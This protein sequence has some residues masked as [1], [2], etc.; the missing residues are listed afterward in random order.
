MLFLEDVQALLFLPRIL[1]TIPWFV[2]QKHS[3]RVEI[4]KFSWLY[5]ISVASFI[6][7]ISIWYG[8]DMVR[9]ARMYLMLPTGSYI[10]N[11]H[12]LTE[13]YT[14]II[15]YCCVV[16]FCVKNYNNII[17]VINSILEIDKEI[18]DNLNIRFKMSQK[19]YKLFAVCLVIYC[20]LLLYAYEKIIRKRV[21]LRNRI[22]LLCVYALQILI[23]SFY[24]MFL[25]IVAQG[26]F[27]RFKFLNKRIQMNVMWQTDAKYGA[28]N[29]P[30]L[31]GLYYKLRR[32]C[33]EFNESSG[34]IILFHMSF[35]FLSIL[36]Q[37]YLLIVF[38]FNAQETNFKIELFVLSI[39]WCVMLS[40]VSGTLSYYCGNISEEVSCYFS[41]GQS[42]RGCF[43]TV[44]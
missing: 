42:E 36:N 20:W 40:I 35:V 29:L 22:I 7:V 27:G 26:I 9:N 4:V 25:T 1:G 15:S 3:N 18:L 8:M 37:C 44:R 39:S 11:V 41:Y 6:T 14:S 38:Y 32:S 21:I 2:Y 10:D 19:R 13:K 43:C 17:G 30:D 34:I 33:Y 24:I 5:S 16:V 28:R 12:Q 31:F 23:V